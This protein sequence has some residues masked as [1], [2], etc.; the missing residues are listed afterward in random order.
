MEK[1]S[2]HQV[3]SY[4][5]NNPD[6]LK[7]PENKKC[8][9]MTKTMKFEIEIYSPCREAVEYRKGFD[10]FRQAWDACPRGDWMLWLASAVRVNK[11]LLTLAKG[12]CAET[13]KHLMQDERSVRAVETAIAYGLGEATD[14][15]LAT[16]ADA[17]A[18]AAVAEYYAACAA[19][20]AAEYAA[21]AAYSAAD[22]AVYAY[23]YAAADAA[24]YA[25]AAATYA[26]YSAVAASAA[27]TKNQMQTANICRELLT[28]EV[29]KLI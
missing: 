27:R 26:A 20:Y 2:C 7:V 6:Y 11:R 4:P 29:M 1:T 16:A 10:T 23:A 14:E 9:Y 13:V 3:S 22:V 15:Q 12:R 18:D 19:E 24:A 5:A 28:E 25:D 17:A 8:Q 21:V